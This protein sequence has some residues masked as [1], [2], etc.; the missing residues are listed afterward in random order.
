MQR[1]GRRNHEPYRLAR[2]QQKPQHQDENA[3][4]Y[5][6]GLQPMRRSR[7]AQGQPQGRVPAVKLLARLRFL[8]RQKRLL[9]CVRVSRGFGFLA[10]EPGDH[11]VGAPNIE[12]PSGDGAD[13]RTPKCA[14]AVKSVKRPE[15]T[16]QRQRPGKCGVKSALRPPIERAKP[17]GN[18]D[19]QKRRH[20]A[21]ALA[22]ADGRSE[23]SGAHGIKRGRDADGQNAHKL[24]ARHA[25]QQEREG[26][27]G[28]ER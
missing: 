5:E 22:G 13:Q 28:K 6:Y 27:Q 26:H 1:V 4:D 9:V 16:I 17:A 24:A 25:A 11:A 7:I 8:G 19:Q 14:R 3:P 10:S 15:K 12:K 20:C 21:A 2:R 23:Q 18:K